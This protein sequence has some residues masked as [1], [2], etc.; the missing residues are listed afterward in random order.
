MKFLIRHAPYLPT[1]SS[2][3]GANNLL[4]TLFSNTVN[5]CPLFR[6]TDQ[7]LHTSDSMCIYCYNFMYSILYMP[8]YDGRKKVLNWMVTNIHHISSAVNF[9]VDA[10]LIFF[11]IVNSVAIFSVNFLA[12]FVLY[13]A[14]LWW[15]D[16]NI[17]VSLSAFVSRPNFVLASRKILFFFMM[18]VP[19]T[20][21]Y[22]LFFIC[23][24]KLIDWAALH[25]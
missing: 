23:S 9:I 17:T 22:S 11:I 4:C 18:C 15:Q 3:L 7:H 16:T 21:K 6:T 2:L 12:P 19:F 5:V 10:I 20:S 8:K 1:T 14:A 13:C 24:T 25:W